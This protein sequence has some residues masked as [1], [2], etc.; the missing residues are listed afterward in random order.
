MQNYH[1]HSCWSDPNSRGDSAV[2]QEDYAKRAV[3]LGHKVLSSVEH[4]WQG[5]Y[6]ETFEVAQKYG[7]KFVFGAE[8]YWVLDRH[9]QDRTN[10]HM[11][12]LA[13]TEKGRQAINEMLSTANEDGYYYRPRI[14]LELIKSLPPNDVVITTACIAGWY[15]GFEKSEEIFLELF[16]IFGSN[17][18]LEI[19][20]HNIPLQIETNQHILQMHEKYGIPMIVALDSHYIDPSQA[21]E[22]DELLKSNGIFYE[23]EQGMFLDYPSDDEVRRRFADQGV[24]TPQQVQEAMDNTDICLTFEDYAKDNPIFSS[25]IKIPS[26]FPDKT[27]EEKNSIYRK[28]ITRQFKKFMQ[29]VPK[30]RYQEYWQAVKD[31]VDTYIDTNL[32]DYPLMDYAIV[33]KA[34]QM[35]GMITTTGRGSAASYLTNTLCGF[36]QVDRLN[37]PIKLYPDR[38]I[39]KTRILETHSLPDLDLNLGNVEIFAQAQEEILGKDHAI[40]MIAFGTAKKKSAFKIYARAKDMDFTL[41]NTISRQI[42]KYDKAVANAEEDEK[43]EIDIYDYVDEQYRPYIEASKKYWGIITDRKKAPCAYLLYQ[44]SIRKE[45]GLIKC[46]SE[47]TKKEYMVAV[48]DGAVAEH[49][50]FLKN[51]LLKVDVVLLI[52]SIFKRLGQE[53]FNVEELRKTVADDPAVWDIY[54]KGLTIGVNQ[55]EKPATMEKLKHYKP[56]NVSELAAFI[57]AIRPGFKSMYR[58]FESREPFSYGIPAL[59]NLIQTREIKDSYIL[60]Q[61]NLMTILNY[62]SFAMSETY[63]AVK[64]IAKKKASKVKALKDKFEEGCTKQIVL[65][66]HVSESDAEEISARIWRIINDSSSYLFNACLS[67]DTLIKMKKSHEGKTIESL[68]HM[69]R[70]LDWCIK[71]NKKRLFYLFQDIGFCGYGYSMRPDEDNICSKNRII[72]IRQAGIR[73]TYRMTLESGIDVVATMNHKFPT[74]DGEKQLSD[75]KVGDRIYVCDKNLIT[76]TEKIWSIEFEKKQMTYDVEME[77]PYHNFV[78]QNGMV[79]S[80]SHAYCMALDSLYCAYLKAHYPYEFYEVLLQFYSDKGNKD[81]VNLI[82]REMKA[83][84]INEGRYKFGIDNRRFQADSENHQIIPSLLSIKSLSQKCANIMY[85]LGQQSFPDFIHLYNEAQKEGINSRQ[86]NILINI[87]YFSDFGTQKQLDLQVEMLELFGWKEQRSVK[88]DLIPDFLQDTVRRYTDESG[89]FLIDSEYD[90][91]ALRR[92]RDLALAQKVTDMKNDF[93][94]KKAAQEAIKCKLS[95]PQ[96]FEYLNLKC[97]YE[98]RIDKMQFDIVEAQKRKSLTC[99]LDVCSEIN[100]TIGEYGIIEKIQREF[101]CLGYLASDYSKIK[102]QYG[103]VSNVDDKYATRKIT[104]YRICDGEIITYKVFSRTWESLPLEEKDIIRILEAKQD[105]KRTKNDA[106]EWV[107][108]SELEWILQKYDR[109]ENIFS[110]ST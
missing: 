93:K 104:V 14:D 23:D 53:V 88:L 79:V 58:R 97:E 39:S 25:D 90:I 29:T 48:I 33:E 102:S 51:D 11:I 100:R 69:S 83:F 7:L 87:G 107:P 60:F 66:E 56:H 65:D 72:D 35:G 30:E 109:L 41:A 9:Q 99:L 89:T 101:S 50:K 77:A 3:E 36:S 64:D 4:G 43:D 13:K 45:I 47:S 32:V 59:D 80:N 55:C 42:E 76:H 22:R 31:E 8:A 103:I 15:Y 27:Q 91:E 26:I 98:K 5:Y 57:A 52:E 54:A 6:F 75:L 10:C 108:T 70:D 68:Y 105:Y 85:E 95:H 71:N 81:K 46:K 96:V 19:Q 28:L 24:F 16:K 40:P 38:F 21:V 20:Y 78:L 37:S 82:K 12:I 34:K 94:T 62:A 61:E 92:E 110:K 18:F 106:G 86:L 84:G 67:G 74:P 2:F 73:D 63:Q 49:Y 44:G 1:K 17:F